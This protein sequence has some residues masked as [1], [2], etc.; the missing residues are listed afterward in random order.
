MSRSR[1][2]P[3]VQF[4]A[5]GILAGLALAWFLGGSVVPNA[6]AQQAATRELNG[7]IAFTTTGGAGPTQLLYLIDTR[8]QA[9]A[10]YRVDPSDPNGAVK[11]EGTRQYRWDLQLSEYNNHEPNVVAVQSMVGTARR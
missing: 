6:F 4:L 9:F 7:T 5:L 1:W 8:N 3:S 2:N 10:V 11:L